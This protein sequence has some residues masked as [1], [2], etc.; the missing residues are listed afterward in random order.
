MALRKATDADTSLI[1]NIADIS[2]RAA[3]SDILSKEQ[4]DYMLDSMYSDEEIHNQLANL[5][6]HYF[7]VEDD[8]D[9]NKPVG[10]IGYEHYVEAHTTK[11]HRIYLIPDARGKGFGKE[12]ILFARYMAEARG[13]D[14]LI[15]NVNKENPAKNIYESLGFSVYDEIV[16]DI[17]NGYVMDDYMMELKW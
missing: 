10:Y 13:N 11:L 6:Y 2:W 17:G 12:A 7:I 9:H 8:Q 14:R 1:Q 5:D 16:L 3:Y 4:I 15:L